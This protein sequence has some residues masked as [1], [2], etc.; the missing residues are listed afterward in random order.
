MTKF[1]SKKVIV[2][3]PC[4]KV[5]D[6]IADF[7]NFNKLLPKEV[8]NWKTDGNSCTFKVDN[9]GNLS[10]KIASKTPPNQINIVSDGSNP[11]DYTLDCHFYSYDKDKCEVEIIFEAELT[12][13]V[14]MIASDP[15]QNFIDILA[16]K[17]KEIFDKN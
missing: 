13:F 6:F 8:S 17:I 5:Y 2:N 12:S 3:A 14:E 15:L 4:E 10:M 9:I 7:N 1:T 16:N 11:I